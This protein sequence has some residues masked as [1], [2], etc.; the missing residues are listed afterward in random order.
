MEEEYKIYNDVKCYRYPN[1]DKYT[2]RLY[3]EPPFEPLHPKEYPTVKIKTPYGVVEAEAHEAYRMK[4]DRKYDEVKV[5][6]ITVYD[7]F[8]TR[9]YTSGGVQTIDIEP[10]IKKI[11]RCKV[12]NDSGLRILRCDCEDV[13]RVVK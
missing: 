4:K 5:D 1:D 9:V 10:S 2:C 3:K 7:A 13:V 11:M 8:C 6:E 12:Y